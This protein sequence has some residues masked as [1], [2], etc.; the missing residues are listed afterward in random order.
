MSF[1]TQ[2]TASTMPTWERMEATK[3]TNAEDRFMIETLNTCGEKVKSMAKD[4][5]SGRK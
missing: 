2:L 1:Q 3:A 5:S 4:S